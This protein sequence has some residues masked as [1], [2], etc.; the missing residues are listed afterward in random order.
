MNTGNVVVQTWGKSIINVYVYI[1]ICIITIQWD[2]REGS[3]SIPLGKPASFGAL[4]FFPATTPSNASLGRRRRRSHWRDVR[5]PSH[6]DLHVSNLPSG[7]VKI[8]IE[9]GH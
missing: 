7:Y 5:T 9:N 6:G 3:P 2:L 8:A 4:K 1:Y